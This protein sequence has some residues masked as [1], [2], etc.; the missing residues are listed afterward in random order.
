M[1]DNDQYI[2][3]LNNTLAGVASEQ[4]SILVFA[5]FSFLIRYLTR[6]DAATTNNSTVVQSI[7]SRHEEEGQQGKEERWL[8]L[9]KMAVS[10]TSRVE[11]YWKR[12]RFLA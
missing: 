5:T 2:T 1:V 4:D 11:L 8:Q 7:C 10:L 9:R 6:Y 3:R 12:R